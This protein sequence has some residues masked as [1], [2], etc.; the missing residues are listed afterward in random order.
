MTYTAEALKI[1][2]A[3]AMTWYDAN[4]YSDAY[5]YST[6]ERMEMLDEIEELANALE[7]I[8]QAAA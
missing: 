5:N 1:Q 8:Q 4:A 3:N 6:E 7:Q 2:L